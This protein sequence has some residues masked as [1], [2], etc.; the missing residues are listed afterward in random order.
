MVVLTTVNEHLQLL[1]SKY[2]H[3]NEFAVGIPSIHAFSASQQQY[4]LT[5]TL[6]VLGY[7]FVATSILAAG[8]ATEFK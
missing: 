2:S 4:R 7:H 3:I 5:L 6:G 8:G 1:F